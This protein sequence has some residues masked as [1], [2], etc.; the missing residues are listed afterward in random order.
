[1]NSA[2]YRMVAATAAL[3]SLAAHEPASAAPT[4]PEASSPQT[5]VSASPQ[6]VGAIA[7]TPM[8][9]PDLP[10]V[11][12]SS[13]SSNI[14]REPVAGATSVPSATASNAVPFSQLRHYL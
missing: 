10:T 13:G 9:T 5:N 7:P 14:N 2:L 4:Q 12:F 6:A 1:M 11:D 8:A 3:G